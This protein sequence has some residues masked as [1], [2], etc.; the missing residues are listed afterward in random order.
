MKRISIFLLLVALFPASAYCAGLY[1]AEAYAGKDPI[2]GGA[3]YTKIVDRSKAAFIVST[4]D[5]LKNALGKAKPGEIIY[6]TDNSVIDMTGQDHVVIPGG[7]TIAGNRGVD[8]S[9]GPIIK[10]TNLECY[11]LFIT[12]GEDVRL[13]GIRFQGPDPE[14]RKEA[15]AKLLSCCIT[16]T[17][18]GLEVDN[19]EMWGW[20][21]A[22]IALTNAGT[23]HKIHHNYIHHC[24]RQGLGYGVCLGRSQADIIA[25]RFVDNRHDIA[26]TGREGTS[27]R[28]CYN[29]SEA[30]DP[31]ISHAFD[32]HGNQESRKPGEVVPNF[33]GDSIE[34]FNNTFKS[35]EPRVYIAIRGEPRYGITIHHNIYENA[36][37][38]ARL[39]PPCANAIISDDLFKSP[40]TTAY[41]LF[42]SDGN[43]LNGKQM[44]AGK[45]KRL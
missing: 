37:I 27:Y 28:A 23:G 43:M 34:I 2:G 15:G 3:G 12:M 26:G 39:K 6:V 32:M 13:T 10:T 22:A 42:E 7:I 24:R 19:C 16:T 9:L 4:A 25:N 44:K 21:F 29:I 1:G 33:A 11:P 18:P 41:Y 40:P 8:G 38:G 31:P 17:K 14:I 20:S 35:K 36:S 45:I 5:E 30:I